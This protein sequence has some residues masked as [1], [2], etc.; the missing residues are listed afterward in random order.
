MNKARANDHTGSIGAPS[1]MS[2]FYASSLAASVTT[3]TTNP[4]SPDGV[5][6]DLSSSRKA[7]LVLLRVLCPMLE[8]EDLLRLD[9]VG[10]A[11]ETISTSTNSTTMDDDLRCGGGALLDEP[12]IS[13]VD[14]NEPEAPELST[15]ASSPS[16]SPVPPEVDVR[17]NASSKPAAVGAKSGSNNKRRR[18]KRSAAPPSD[19]TASASKRSKQQTSRFRGVSRCTKDGRWQ[20]RIRVKAGVCYLG[21][22]VSEVEAAKRYDGAARE[23]HGA[24]AVLNFPTEEDRAKGMHGVFELAAEREEAV[25]SS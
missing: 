21:R 23:H 20:A 24:L 2:S 8:R 15:S 11:V 17:S 9:A 16:T 18:R 7:G 13:F 10:D 25:S 4:P 1:H 12:T 5:V 3:T 6:W 19:A 22:F 14:T